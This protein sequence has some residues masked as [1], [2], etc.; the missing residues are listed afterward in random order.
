MTLAVAFK[1]RLPIPK[2]YS[3]ASATI[4]H[5]PSLR[6]VGAVATSSFFIG[7][8]PSR[9]GYCDARSSTRSVGMTLAVAFKPRLPIPKEYSVASATIDSSPQVSF[10]VFNTVLV[11][12]RQIL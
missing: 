7:R 5:Q 4:E 1:P 11:Q 12:K 6:D 9:S 8:L 3:V 2:Q 10:V